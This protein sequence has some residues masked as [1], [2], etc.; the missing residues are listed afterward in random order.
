MQKLD[1]NHDVMKRCC[2]ASYGMVCMEVYDRVKHAGLETW[3][4]PLDRKRYVKEQIDWFVKK[5]CPPI[6]PLSREKGIGRWW[7]WRPC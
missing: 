1:L 4:D 3:T 7:R 6:P 5:V 2:R